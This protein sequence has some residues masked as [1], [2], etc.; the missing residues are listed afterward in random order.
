MTKQ[1]AFQKYA[2]ACADI[3]DLEIAIEAARFAMG[4]LEVK[5]SKKMTEAKNFKVDWQKLLNN[6]AKAMVSA[7]D[8]ASE[9]EM[10]VV[11]NA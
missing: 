7:Q 9:A 1:E 3:G 4:D 11:G 6:E 2:N 5:K 8:P 10:A